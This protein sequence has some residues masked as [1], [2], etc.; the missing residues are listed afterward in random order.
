MWSGAVVSVVTVP[1]RRA[2][3]ADAQRIGEVLADAFGDYPWTRWTIDARDH[4]RR[5]A[6]LQRLSLERVGL[7]F[8][9]VWVA[10][11]D[12]AIEAAAVWMHSASNV[13]AEV[14]TAMEDE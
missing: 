2:T 10:T 8:G 14:L 3:E 11:L 5:I 1:V 12:D 6:D 4:R 9:Q 13:P 7:P